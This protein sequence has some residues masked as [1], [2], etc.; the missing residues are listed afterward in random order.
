MEKN[1][2]VAAFAAALLTSSARAEGLRVCGAA[3]GAPASYEDAAAELGRNVSPVVAAGVH[4]FYSFPDVQS[5]VDG[6]ENVC[7]S[8]MPVA[9]NIYQYDELLVVVSGRDKAGSWT[10]PAMFQAAS[11]QAYEN[12]GVK[13]WLG[14]SRGDLL[15]QLR[16]ALSSVEFK[17]TTL[18]PGESF[19]PLAFTG[20]L[21]A[22]SST[23]STVSKA[24]RGYVFVPDVQAGWSTYLVSQLRTLATGNVF[25]SQSLVDAGV[26]Q[27]DE[28]SGRVRFGALPG[29]FDAYSTMERLQGEAAPSSLRDARARAQRIR[30]LGR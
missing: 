10:L 4:Q 24:D 13:P 14:F 22:P 3:N 9:K 1:L 25:T 16:T 5:L 23:A 28:A 11:V 18:Q 6:S 21:F 12:L 29:F 26:V 27:V 8:A 19:S 15:T 7:V 17:E 2:V 20:E 30:D